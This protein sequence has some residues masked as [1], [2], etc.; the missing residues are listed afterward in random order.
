V[1]I[2]LFWYVRLNLEMGAGSVFTQNSY[3]Q[4]SEQLLDYNENLTVMEL[5]MGF[6]VRM[7]SWLSVGVMYDYTF[8]AEDEFG[9]AIAEIVGEKKNAG[10]AWSNLSLTMGLHF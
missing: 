4:G 3:S 8:V 2:P 1:V 6:N 10:M 5:G 7:Y 9:D